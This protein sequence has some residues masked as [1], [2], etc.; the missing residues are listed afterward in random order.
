MSTLYLIRHGQA[1]FG[2]EDYDVLSEFG[3]RQS[4]RLGEHLAEYD[5]PIDALYSG[6]RK[7]QIDTATH[8]IAAV[9]AAGG[10][11]CEAKVLDE[12]DEYPAFELLKQWMPVLAAEDADFQDLMSAGKPHHIYER[13][14]DHIIGKWIRGELETG[15]LESYEQFCARVQRG[16]ERVMAATGR[17]AHV[18]VVTSGGPIAVTMQCTLGLAAELMMKVAWVTANASMSELRFRGPAIADLTLVSFNS[19]TH[20]RKDDL[21]TYR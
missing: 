5:F 8:M 20:L 2:A 13:A 14:F 15:E 19:F 17:G 4:R 1:S 11:I 18:A 12:F 16:L 21:V 9:R 6:P 7:R 10:E 3:I